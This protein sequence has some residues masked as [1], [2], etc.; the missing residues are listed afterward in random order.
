MS[1]D[2]KDW[3]H[4]DVYTRS[5]SRGNQLPR[6]S[7]FKFGLFG[8]LIRNLLKIIGQSL[9]SGF[10][11]AFLWIFLLDPTLKSNAG[12]FVTTQ[13]IIKLVCSTISVF[14]AIRIFDD[15]NLV[16]V[17]LKMDR[18][19][20]RDFFAGFII[21]ALVFSFEFVCYL[22]Y[23]WIK[24]EHA[25]WETQSLTSI[26]LKTLAVLIIFLFT[27]WSEEL[28]SRGFHLRILS[29]GL[30]R[31]LG[32]I[33]SSVIFS[34][35][36]HNNPGMNPSGYIFIFLSGIVFSLAFLRTGQLWLAMGLHAGWDFFVAV[37]WGT[38]ISGLRLFHLM[39]FNLDHFPLPSR[40]SEFFDLF[41]IVVFIF[42]YTLL[43]ESKIQEW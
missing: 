30:N 12:Y 38:P 21:V 31:P 19:A 10:L 20:F 18:M 35:L 16:S 7:I 11:F 6:L 15:S 9:I 2:N 39:E 24:I 37:L 13:E 28:L 17:G 22:G 14:L 25:V 1:D 3:W 4:S 26:L 33:L 36:H 29:K 32:I 43:R 8:D 40:I 27:G 23:G 5:T 41:V 42:L 34:Y